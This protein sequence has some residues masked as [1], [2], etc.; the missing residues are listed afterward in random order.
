MNDYSLFIDKRL[1]VRCTDLGYGVFTDDFIKKGTFVEMAPVIVCSEQITDRNVFKYVLAW[2]NNVA[3]PL[4]WT[5]LYNHS[6]N[7]SCEFST[8]IQYNL[9]A[10][11]ALR[12]I[13]K[14][15]QLTVSY[16]PE[17]FS[18]RGLEKVLL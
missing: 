14:N 13:Q 18:S 10:V 9:L 2:N 3:I 4:G 17:W 11:I 12:D 1:S 7:N 16:G 15:E 8:N 5:G 6:D